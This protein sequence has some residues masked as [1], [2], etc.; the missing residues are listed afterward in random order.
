M[1]Y[2]RIH[3]PE[4]TNDTDHLFVSKVSIGCEM[5][6]KFLPMNVLDN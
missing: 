2:I 5:K 4:I 6:L 3:C 1:K